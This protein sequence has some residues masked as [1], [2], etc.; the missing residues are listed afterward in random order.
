M[1]A[2]IATYEL[3]EGRASE[4]IAA[5]QPAIER[6]RTLDGLV[7]AYFFV[8]RDGQHAVSLTLWDTLD[9]MERSSVAAAAARTDA[10]HDAGA[11][12]TSAHELEVGIHSGGS[13]AESMLDRAGRA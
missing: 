8:E 7:E 12:V 5:F 10:A 6:I 2:R 4:S 9:A 1:F 11:V 3:A 13:A